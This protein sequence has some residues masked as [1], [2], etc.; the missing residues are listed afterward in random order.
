MLGCT[1]NNSKPD[2]DELRGTV[3]NQLKLIDGKVAVAF[4]EIDKPNRSILIN[5][6]EKFHAASTMKTPVMIELYK[7][8]SQGN[9]R[10]SDSITVINEFRSIVDGSSFS[11]D[12]AIDGGEALY[13]K[14]GKQV[15]IYDL[16]YQM[17]TVSSNLA[18][19]ILIQLVDAK[20]VTMSMRNLGALQIE[21]LRG[22]EDQ[23]AYDQGLSNSTTARDL[24]KIMKAIATGKAGTKDDCLQ[25]V[26]IL[27]DQKFNDLIP[28]KLPKEV[29][30]AH[31]TGS[32]TG[33]HHDSGIVY[34][35][36]GRSYV[37][38]LLSKELKNFNEGTL[39]LA[40]LSRIIY[41]FTMR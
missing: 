3:L 6:D 23:K 35:P 29:I 28:A 12:I 39:Q 33:V 19:N 37:L 17:I 22:V 34:L 32:I 38:I 1:S 36:D 25:M 31:K 40:E 20:S 16:M 13:S 8:A 4:Y 9:F 41:D 2:L 15:A 30:V 5:V 14:L 18:T 11:M 27:K 21:V 26:E 24:M 10:L 7:Q